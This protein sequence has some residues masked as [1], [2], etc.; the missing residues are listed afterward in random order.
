MLKI[1]DGHNNP[2]KAFAMGGAV[3]V[4]LHIIHNFTDILC[5]SSRYVMLLKFFLIK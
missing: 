4:W 5:I 3:I 2:K 1:L